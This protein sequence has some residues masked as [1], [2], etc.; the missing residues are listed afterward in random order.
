MLSPA[1]AG[2][3]TTCSLYIV[4]AGTC[5]SH[6]GATAVRVMPEDGQ[7]AEDEPAVAPSAETATVAEV[8]RLA[9]LEA[10]IRGALEGTLPLGRAM[11]PWELQK[12]SPVHLQMVFDKASGMKGVEIAAK[13]GVDSAR[14]YTILGHPHAEA[15]LGELMSVQAD[16]IA[17][18][19]ERMKSF[20]H[21][22]INTK[23][24]LVRDPQSPRTLRNDIAG[25]FLDRAGYGARKKLDIAA[26]HS[27]KIPAEAAHRLADALEASK[28]IEEIDYADFVVQPDSLPAPKLLEG[29]AQSASLALTPSAGHTEASDGASP[30]A[31]PVTPEAET[32]RQETLARDEF[33]QRLR[34]RRTA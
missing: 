6:Q 17:D 4:H 10:T 1:G 21:E 22:M 11:K 8:L 15:L 12:L 5:A 29:E 3:T 33:T 34:K 28:R 18:P 2:L 24:E 14:V 31:L 19:I 16:R 13:H 20:S 7:R 32:K 25:D 27:I 26:E 9:R 23:L 30:D